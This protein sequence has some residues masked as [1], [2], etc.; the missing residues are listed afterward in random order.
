MKFNAWSKTRILDGRKTLTSRKKQYHDSDV[1][2]VVGP[3]PWWFIKKYLYRDEG[4]ESPD[5]LQRVINGIFRRTV[6]E[7]EEFY[8]HILDDSCLGRL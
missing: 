2:A 1:L 4:A 3:L 6:G 7:L 8:V 5:E